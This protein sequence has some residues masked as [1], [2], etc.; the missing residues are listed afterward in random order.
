MKPNIFVVGPSGSG[1]STSLR[2]LDPATTIILNTEQKALPFRTGGNFRLNVPIANMDAFHTAFDKA[3]KSEIAKTI[4][5]ESFTSMIEQQLISSGK[6]YTG[7][8]LWEDY[9]TEI[10][11]ILNLSKGTDKYVIF[12]GLDGVFEG[13]NGVEERFIYVQGSLKKQIEKEFVIVLYTNMITNTEGKSE[14]RFVTNKQK[15]YEHTGVKSPMEMLELTMPNDLSLVIE[16]IEKYYQ[17]TEV[18]PTPEAVVE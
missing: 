7:Y 12:L 1:K 2:N 8:D 13:V 3:L 17:P 4:I 15:G 9:K 5:I 14:Y 6:S 16:K 18:V 10:Q 11:R